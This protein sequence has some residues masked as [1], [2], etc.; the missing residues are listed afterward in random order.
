M[1]ITKKTIATL[2]LVSAIT[3]VGFSGCAEETAGHKELF[4]FESYEDLLKVSTEN[5]MGGI[6]ACQEEGFFTQG[7]G[8]MKLSVSKP[9]SYNYH[10]YSE[11]KDYLTPTLVVPIAETDLSTVQAFT[12]DVYN[13]N[14]YDTGVYLYTKEGEMTDWSDERKIGF[15]AYA[16]AQK[17]KWNKLSFTVNGEFDTGKYKRLFVSVV[18]TNENTT[19]YFDSLCAVEGTSKKPNVSSNGS[20]VLAMNKSEEVRALDWYTKGSLPASYLAL[21]SDPVSGESVTALVHEPFTGRKDP[22][23]FEYDDRDYG[24]NVWEEV[25]KNYDFQGARKIKLEVYN[26][27][28]TTKKIT[29][30]ISDGTNVAQ[31]ETEVPMGQ[32]TTI[33]VNNLLKLDLSKIENIGVTL[34][35]YDN[36]DAG[37]IYFRNLAVEE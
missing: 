10:R 34:K 12:L 15:C 11:K 26:G 36:F 20:T 24:F 29:L 35:A 22:A 8:G 25:V 37:T 16:V 33:S 23:S 2:A 18:D 32:W 13:A 7:N 9:A 31:R 19:Y 30:S 6:K 1:K 5:F 27:M 3:C 14:D 17:G 28:K 21:G 4:G